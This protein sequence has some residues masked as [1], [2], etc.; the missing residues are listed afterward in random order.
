MEYA[1]WMGLG[2]LISIVFL[3]SDIKYTLKDTLREM[4]RHHKTMNR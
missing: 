3:L 4:K 2:A 1:V